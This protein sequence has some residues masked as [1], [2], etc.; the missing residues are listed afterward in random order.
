V[1]RPRYCETGLD[2]LALSWASIMASATWAT[3]NR[4]T[5]T[6]AMKNLYDHLTL[7]MGHALP[8]PAYQVSY[9]ACAE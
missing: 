1:H 4:E 9:S 6:R 5:E 3:L 2:F 8:P 7:G